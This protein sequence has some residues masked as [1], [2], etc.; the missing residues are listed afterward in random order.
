MDMEVELEVER[1]AAEAMVA[2]RTFREFRM[3][4]GG[5]ERGCLMD[6]ARMEG[7][8]GGLAVEDDLGSGTNEGF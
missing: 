5:E 8:M 7:V 1:E 6:Q 3:V 2:R 4:S